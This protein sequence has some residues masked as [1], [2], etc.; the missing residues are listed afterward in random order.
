MLKTGGELACLSGGV[1]AGR[2]ESQVGQEEMRGQTGDGLTTMPS[3]PRGIEKEEELAGR[4]VSQRVLTLEQID[5]VIPLVVSHESNSERVYEAATAASVPPTDRPSM[6]S[7]QNC[8]SGAG[9]SVDVR[10]EK[11]TNDDNG[12]HSVRVIVCIVCILDLPACRRRP[13]QD[14]IC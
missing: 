10:T 4:F 7:A 11:C 14:V 2:A 5:R 12:G 3:T 9:G 13:A 1:T 8:R 6:T